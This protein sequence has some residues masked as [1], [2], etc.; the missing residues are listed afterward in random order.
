MFVTFY[1]KLVAS[2]LHYAIYILHL[3]QIAI[4]IQQ[5]YN[6]MIIP[7]RILKEWK[8]VIEDAGVMN[9]ASDAGVNYRTIKRT[10][11]LGQCKD[12]TYDRLAAY[13]LV[14]KEFVRAKLQP[15]GDNN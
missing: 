11:D 2:V 7:K 14:R 8:K 5:I 12:V 4:P 13:V 6:I 15:Q 3:L 10:L 1:Y 9:A